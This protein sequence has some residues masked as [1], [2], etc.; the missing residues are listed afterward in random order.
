MPWL[1]LQRNSPAQGLV[2]LPPFAS[3]YQ[4]VSE[5]KTSDT[6]LNR[7]GKTPR[8]TVTGIRKGLC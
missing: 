6:Q 8:K 3:S 7:S 5:K 4:E 1:L 2:K